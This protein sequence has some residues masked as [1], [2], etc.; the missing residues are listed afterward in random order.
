MLVAQ[1]LIIYPPE[2]R[3]APRREVVFSPYLSPM[4]ETR[5]PGEKKDRPVLGECAVASFTS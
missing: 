2:T 4:M 1:L 3:K 5:G